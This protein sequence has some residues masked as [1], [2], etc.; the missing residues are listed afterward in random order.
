MVAKTLFIL[1]LLHMCGQH[2]CQLL[3]YHCVYNVVNLSSS[4][5]LA[6]VVRGF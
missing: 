5:A 1:F 4:F 2:Y 6:A 3:A